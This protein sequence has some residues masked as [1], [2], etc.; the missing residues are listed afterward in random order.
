M[1]KFETPFCTHTIVLHL[2]LGPHVRNLLKKS[3]FSI[4]LVVPL[5]F[6]VSKPAW[7]ERADC[8]PHSALPRVHVKKKP[9]I[10]GHSRI[11]SW[12]YSSNLRPLIANMNSKFAKKIMCGK[13]GLPAGPSKGVNSPRPFW[14][15]GVPCLWLIIQVS[16]TSPGMN[17]KA[18]VL[19]T[20]YSVKYFMGKLGKI[21]LLRICCVPHPRHRRR[22][23]HSV[24]P[25][26]A[27]FQS[28]HMHPMVTWSRPMLLGGGKK[29]TVSYELTV[30]V[31]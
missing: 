31:Q 9:P 27:R 3:T 26:A 21:A 28:I 4:N 19:V 18:W 2:Y 1:K 7:W 6:E 16:C 12:L 5:Q 11:Y 22:S 15:E 8:P 13:Q 17:R 30:H 10:L 29:S 24:C 14:W 25:T 23:R 20:E